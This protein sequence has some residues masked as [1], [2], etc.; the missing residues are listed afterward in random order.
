[1]DRVK[2]TTTS[3]TTAR[4]NYRHIQPNVEYENDDLIFT[5]SPKDIETINEDKDVVICI[6]IWSNNKSDIQEFKHE[7]IIKNNKIKITFSSSGHRYYEIF[8]YE[9]ESGL[10][11]YSTGVT[12][13]LEDCADFEGGD[14]KD[15]DQGNK[16]PFAIKVK[17]D[18]A[19]PWRYEIEYAHKYFIIHINSQKF[20]ELINN[21]SG[22]GK[23][24]S[25]DFLR[26]ALI[27]CAYHHVYKHDFKSTELEKHF[28]N[29]V[30]V[31]KRSIGSPLE[32]EDYDEDTDDDKY[33]QWLEWIDEALGNFFSANFKQEFH[34]YLNERSGIDNDE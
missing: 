23:L 26:S 13:L 19:I 5:F 11:K 6:D 24:L 21:T 25:L 7:D 33:Q 28:L 16:P 2:I 4:S 10:K 18:Q 1:V 3:K 29:I 31:L 32:A 12:A 22:L 8:G 15:K 27:K 20:E 9:T 34:N 14:G 17:P 30:N